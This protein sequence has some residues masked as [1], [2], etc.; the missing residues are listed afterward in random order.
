MA[1]LKFHDLDRNPA[2]GEK[3]ETDERARDS[4]NRKYYTTVGLSSQYVTDWIR[5]HVPGKVVLDY[6]CGNGAKALLAAEAGAALAFGMDISSVSV[7]NCRAQALARGLS[8]N[9]CFFQG[10]CEQT[11]LPPRSVDVILCHGMLH[12]LDLSYAFSEMRRILRPGGVVF[13]VEALNYNPVIR[14]YRVLTPALRTPYERAHILSHKDVRFAARFFQVS[15]VR[16][17]HLWSI[18]AVVFRRTPL[19][20]AAL[21][22]GDFLDRLCL[23]IPWLRL[24]AWM[25]TFELHKRPE[26][27]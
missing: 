19:F 25:F 23:S 13:C 27:D 12:H 26:D 21:T 24:W 3:S 11:E 5:G 8:Q 1:E 15:N 7:R 10:D 14:L 20:G 6:A 2:S 9:A 17:W 22:T 16:Y 18:G 4:A